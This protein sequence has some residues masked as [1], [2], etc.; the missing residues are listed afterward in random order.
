VK[1]PGL[2]LGR[3]GILAGISAMHMKQLELC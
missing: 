2:S 3:D 1:K